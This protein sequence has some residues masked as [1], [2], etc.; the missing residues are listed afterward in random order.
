MKINYQQ[1]REFLER[2][3][4]NDNVAIITHNDMDGL[5]SGML[6]RNF[7]IQRGCK[8]SV[9]FLNYGVNKISDFDLGKFNKILVSDLAPGLICGEMDFMS[10]KK[11]LYV[12]HHQDDPNFP[13]SEDI[14]ELRTTSEGY[15]P[16]S[17]TC[18]ELTGKENKDIQW[19]SVVGVLGDMGHL[20]E[21]NKEFLEK[22][23]EYSGKSFEVCLDATKKLN[24]VI[25]Y[26]SPKVEE[27]FEKFIELKSIE[28]VNQ[29]S[30]YS[31]EVAEEFM[32]LGSDFARNHR[33]FGK[34][35]YFEIESKFT[36]IK[37]ALVTSLCSERPENVFV[38]VSSKNNGNGISARNASK[39]YDVSKILKKCAEGL[40]NS[41]AGGHKSA[42]GA[43]IMKEDLDKF[44][45]NLTKIK[46]EEY[47]A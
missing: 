30:E 1:A 40:K 45:E 36:G 10:D 3:N 13:I 26:F 46:L 41:S 14:L 34:I 32:R 42:A 21:I 33:V 18:F 39:K 25:I 4:K 28:D 17:R 7:C 5:C 20:Y 31:K 12:D 37:S 6:F 23:Y 44:K 19:I 24:S 2:I 22:F 43:F 9:F 27:A 38:F 35:I 47:K 29:L 15:I 8:F 16:S 11:I